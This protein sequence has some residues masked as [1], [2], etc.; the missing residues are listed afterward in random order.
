MTTKCN[1]LN[2]QSQSVFSTEFKK[3]PV[4]IDGLQANTECRLFGEIGVSTN[5][6]GDPVTILGSQS[7]N[8][9]W[10]RIF[11]S[12]FSS[13]ANVLCSTMLGSPVVCANNAIAG[14]LIS[15]GSCSSVGSN[16]GLNY[17]STSNYVEWLQEVVKEENSRFIVNVVQYPSG[18][19][20][21]STVRCSGTIIT[22]HRVLTTA[23]CVKVPSSMVI[24]IRTEM[25]TQ[26]RTSM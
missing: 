14:F 8:P 17:H 3:L 2:F 1:N 25:G 11:C 21:D 13:E 7:C 23:S 10:L 16:V 26:I 4:A 9:S 24:G 20:R 12:T 15:D 6:R 19:I 22:S 5:S 18:N